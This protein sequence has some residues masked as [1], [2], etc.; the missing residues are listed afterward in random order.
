VAGGAGVWWWTAG[1][2]TRFND[3]VDQLARISKEGIQLSLMSMD[4]VEVGDWL[5]TAGAPRT[6]SL[7]D[8]LDVLPRKGC[9][10]YD[11]EGRPVSLEC[12]LLPGMRQLHL[13]T[14]ATRGLRGAPEDQGSRIATENGLTAGSWNRDGKTM[15]LLSEETPETISGLLTDV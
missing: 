1:R 11:I 2:A 6:A 9:H 4:R 8:S 15:I 12:F 5:S 10:L 3:L 14:T 7:P 13:F